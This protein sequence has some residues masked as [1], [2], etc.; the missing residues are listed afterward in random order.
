MERAE[1]RGGGS[2]GGGGREGYIYSPKRRTRVT[3]MM[4]ARKGDVSRSRKM[5]SASIAPALAN[6]QPNQTIQC[7]F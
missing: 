3:E 2:G 1:K 5:G 4:M 7:G 6:P